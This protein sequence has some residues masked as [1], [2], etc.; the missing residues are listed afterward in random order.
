MYVYNELYFI[1]K[2]VW[3]TKNLR[4]VW[5][6]SIVIHT[7]WHDMILIHFAVSQ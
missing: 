6:H 3:Q 1:F 2:I 7:E 4:Q 5:Y